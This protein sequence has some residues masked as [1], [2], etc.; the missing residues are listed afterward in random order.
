MIQRRTLV[1]AVIAAL[2]P[3]SMTSAYA[4]GGPSGAHIGYQPT[5]RRGHESVQDRTAYSDHP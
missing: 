2:A 5:W 1:K 3:L 4:A